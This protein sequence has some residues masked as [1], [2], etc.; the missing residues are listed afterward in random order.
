MLSARAL[1]ATR[2]FGE[3]FSGKM[4]EGSAQKIRPAARLLIGIDPVKRD[5]E[6]SPCTRLSSPACPALSEWSVN[7]NAR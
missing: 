3:S 2:P 6:A 7:L 4:N 1:L 5:V